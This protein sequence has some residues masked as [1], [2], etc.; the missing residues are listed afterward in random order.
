VADKNEKETN[1]FLYL[2]NRNGTHSVHETKCLKSGSFANYWVS[3]C[4]Q[5]YEQFFRALSKYFFGQRWLSST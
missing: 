1:I 4:G 3:T 5:V 2:L